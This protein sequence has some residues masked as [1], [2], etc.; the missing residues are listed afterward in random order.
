VSTSAL[1]TPQH[2][3]TSLLH[4][5]PRAAMRLGRYTQPDSG[6]SRELVSLAAAE[7]SVLVIDRLTGTHADARLVAH[8]AAD[9][10]AENAGLVCALYLADE[11]RG[12]CRP[13]TGR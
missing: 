12:R 13:V 6:A 7:G 1:A 3:E 9:E 8:I 5:T 10:P 2:S 4:D 11:N